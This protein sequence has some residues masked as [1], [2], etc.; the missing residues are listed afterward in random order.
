[1]SS[2][3]TTAIGLLTIAFLG[4]LYALLCFCTV[5]IT[6]SSSRRIRELAKDGFF[7]APYARIILARSHLALLSLQA[8]RFFTTLACG[9]VLWRLVEKVPVPVRWESWS[10]L[11]YLAVML[12]TVVLAGVITFFLTQTAKG[13]ASAAPERGLCIM[14]CPILWCAKIL[15]PIVRP[16]EAGVEA[17]LRLF[18][19][20]KPVEQ[21][22]PVSQEEITELV[23]RGTES[24]EIEVDEREMIR[25]VF[26]ISDTVVREV[27]TP[28]VDVV[29]VEDS[30]TLDEVKAVFAR[31]GLSRIVVCGNT[32]DEVRGILMAKDL[33]PLVGNPTQ[34]DW[35][36]FIRPAHFVQNTIKIDHLLQELRTKGIHFA[37]VL[38]EHGGVDGIITMEDLIEEIVG[39]IFDE[40]DVPGEESGI[41]RT[42][43]GDLLVEG[44]IGIEDLNGGCNIDLPLGEYDTIAGFV[45]H[46]LGRIPGVGESLE[47]PGMRIRV[48]EVDHNRVKLLRISRTRRA[49]ATSSESP[50]NDRASQ[51]IE[52]LSSSRAIATS[53]S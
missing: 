26:S 4:A 46:E 29:A 27:M 44:S 52:G 8:A 32:L 19:L 36:P 33:L 14:A 20:R 48:E 6:R 43:G 51:P 17:F 16:V 24:G 13:W 37:V 39:E 50:S 25:G 31:E 40:Y 47:L 15:R 35:R 5:A 12:A 53:N 9:A 41:R 49:S 28:R 38:D 23:E 42:K 11:F 18:G 21:N 30:A 1:M 2:E 3:F 34:K 22:K 45:I 7:C 10:P